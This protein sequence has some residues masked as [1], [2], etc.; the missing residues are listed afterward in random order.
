MMNDK[1]ISIIIPLYNCEKFILDTVKTI[2]EQTYENWE[3]I[4]VNDCS[5]DKSV[6]KLKPY[7][8]EKIKII[9]LE[10]NSGAAITR[11]IGIENAKGEYIAFLDADDFWHK[12]KLEKQIEFMEKNNYTFTCTNYEYT[13]EYGNRTGKVA[14][15]PKILNYNEALKNTII[16]TSTVMFNVNKLGKELIKMPNLRRGQDTATWWKVLRN[17]NTVYGLD[18]VL[19]Y[20]RRSSNTL[21]SNKFKALKRTWKLYR[22]AEGLSTIKSGYYFLHYLANAIKRR[23]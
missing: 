10:K 5:T 7:L 9:N 22:E 12:E 2:Q 3:A 11:N 6:E 21:S 19:S 14:R 4:F 13:D 1:L 15:V 17:G 8:S 18:I 23:V 16:F 20:Y